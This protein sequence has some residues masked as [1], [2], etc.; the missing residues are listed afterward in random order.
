MI[1]HHPW[2]FQANLHDFSESCMHE[3]QGPHGPAQQLSF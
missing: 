1:L 2:F 3:L